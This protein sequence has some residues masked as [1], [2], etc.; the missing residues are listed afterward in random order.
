[1]SKYFIA[2]PSDWK[3]EIITH[4]GSISRCAEMCHVDRCNIYKSFDGDGY[5]SEK[6]LI[7]ICKKMNLSP[8]CFVDSAFHGYYYSDSYKMTYADYEAIMK[9][10]EIME[11]AGDPS[12]IDYLIP[13]LKIWAGLS[14][15]EIASIPV[16]V[17]LELTTKIDNLI[18]ETLKNCLDSWY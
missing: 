12:G 14:D 15:A 9:A 16:S 8:L 4:F 13:T 11:A 3:N 6:M 7:A 1:M 5:I 10:Q 17:K 2:Y 18:N